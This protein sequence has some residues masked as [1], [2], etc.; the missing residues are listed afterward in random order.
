MKTTIVVSAAVAAVVGFALFDVVP[1]EAAKSGRFVAV[2]KAPSRTLQ[3]RMHKPTTRSTTRSTFVKKGTTRNFKKGTA[4]TFLKKSTIGSGKLNLRSLPRQKA[5]AST[6]FLKGRLAVPPGVKPKLTLTKGPSLK[7]RPRFA[8]F[9]QRHWKGAFFWIAV[10]GIGYLTIPEL[11]YDRFYSCMAVDDPIYDDC[12]YILSYAALEEEEVV[13]ISMPDSAAYRYR[14]KAPVAPADCPS[15]RWDR[16]V[17]RKWNQNY[18]WV[19]L[20]EV[21][22]ITV[23]D[24]YYERFYTY[25]GAAPPNY[26]QACR[27][28]EEAS[29]DGG[30]R[31]LARVTM[32]GDAEYRYEADSTPTQEC[33]S[34]TLQPFVERKWN[35]EFVWVQIPQTGNVTV[36]ED[37]YER[38]YGYASAE[39]PNY[40][41]ACKVLVEAAAADTVMTTGLDTSSDTQ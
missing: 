33:K 17:E 30:E 9:V 34:C 41:A 31:E 26:P 16:F 4:T 12:A 5:V 10:A 35:R 36:P 22:N 21:G 27:V 24:A 13:R 14:A 6:A 32:P 8:P 20:P 7:F 1:A 37:Y 38:F 2:H 19:K 15:C 18:S 29:A 25:A 23:P 28:L 40:A 39:P 11:Y 3:P